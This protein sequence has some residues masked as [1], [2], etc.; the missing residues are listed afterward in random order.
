MISVIAFDADNGAYAVFG[1]A[2]FA[3]EHGIGFG[4]ARGAAEGGSC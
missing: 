1:M 4:A 3:A 2:D